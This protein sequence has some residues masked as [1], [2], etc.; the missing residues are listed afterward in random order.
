MTHGQ[1]RAP[2]DVGEQSY[3]FVSVQLAQGAVGLIGI[4]VWAHDSE[5]MGSE[6]LS[7]HHTKALG[8]SLNF[9]NNIEAAYRHPPVFNFLESCAAPRCS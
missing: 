2:Y 5:R 4:R 8:L 3:A 1:K 7:S 6:D 9:V